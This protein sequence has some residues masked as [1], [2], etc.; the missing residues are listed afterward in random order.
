MGSVEGESPDTPTPR[1]F[2]GA[3]RRAGYRT[4]ARGRAKNGDQLLDWLVGVHSFRT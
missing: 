4:I 1:R 2:N 3:S